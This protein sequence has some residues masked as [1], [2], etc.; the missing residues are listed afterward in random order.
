MVS[1]KGITAAFSMGGEGE[2]GRGWG[3]QYSMGASL[4]VREAID[5]RN[6]VKG[7]KTK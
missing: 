2:V 6:H 7:C 5:E 4:K 1:I 3:K